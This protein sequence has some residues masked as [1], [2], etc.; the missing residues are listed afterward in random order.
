MFTYS[1]LLGTLQERPLLFYIVSSQITTI[2]LILVGY[3]SMEHKKVSVPPF[4]ST[5]DEF[6]CFDPMAS[7]GDHVPIMTHDVISI[8]ILGNIFQSKKRH[9]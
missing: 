5:H 7:H 3:S 8:W 2:S 1:T 9:M 4:S 6:P